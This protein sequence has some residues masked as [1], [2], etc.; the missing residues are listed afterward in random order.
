[1]ARSYGQLLPVEASGCGRWDNESVL[2]NGRELVFSIPRSRWAPQHFTTK[3][4]GVFY[5]RHLWFVPPCGTPGRWL[6]LRLPVY[7]ATTI[8]TGSGSTPR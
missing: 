7:L 6:T 1:M 2:L 3:S 4:N 8:S 5:R